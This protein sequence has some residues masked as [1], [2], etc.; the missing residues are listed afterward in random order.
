M[1]MHTLI[2]PE[3]IVYEADVSSKKRAF[4]KL[5]ERLATSLPDIGQETIFEALINRE[6]LGCTSVGNGIAIPHACLP[7]KTP[8]GALLVVQ[9]GIKMDTPDHKPVHI[10]LALL[11]PSAN[12]LHYRSLMTDLAACMSQ[13]GL[14]EQL[15]N[16]SSQTALLEALQTLCAPIIQPVVTPLAA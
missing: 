6:K 3:R 5:A 2:S 1:D 14:S 9:E 15:C 13:K 8:L 7:I 12:A 4:E 11:V 16:V 10:L